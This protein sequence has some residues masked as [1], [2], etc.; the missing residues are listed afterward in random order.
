MYYIVIIIIIIINNVVVDH[1]ICS[2]HTGIC[3]RHLPIFSFGIRRL[4]VR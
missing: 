4:Y 2:D 1:K 3:R